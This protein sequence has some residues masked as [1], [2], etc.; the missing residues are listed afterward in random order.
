[1]YIYIIYIFRIYG[2]LNFDF[3]PRHTVHCLWGTV[4]CL[5][6][7]FLVLCIHCC[8]KKNYFVQIF[9]L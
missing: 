9:C 3:S 1:M 6:H 7:L 2:F 4:A 8:R 5:L